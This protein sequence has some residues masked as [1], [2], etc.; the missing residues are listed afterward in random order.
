MMEI[1]LLRSDVRDVLN[2]QYGE[3]IP[4]DYSDRIISKLQEFSAKKREI[5]RLSKETPST[6]SI[7]SANNRV[8]IAQLAGRIEQLEAKKA[9]IQKDVLQTRIESLELQTLSSIEALGKYEKSVSQYV[10]EEPEETE[11][12]P[13]VKFGDYMKG[14]TDL[15]GRELLSVLNEGIKQLG[16]SE[17]QAWQTSRNAI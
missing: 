15:L 10:G 16:Y 2:L 7:P 17:Y 3:E 8:L 9:R 14:K 13:G 5:V 12:E 11:I 1:F 6:P 4:P